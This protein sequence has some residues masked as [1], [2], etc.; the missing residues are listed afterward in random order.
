MVSLAQIV[1]EVEGGES[2]LS[3]EGT[4]SGVIMLAATLLSFLV[5]RVSTRLMR[6]D[7]VPWWP[8]SIVSDGRLHVHH[9]VFGII[10]MLLAG[11]VITGIAV[12]AGVP[13][14]WTYIAEQAPSVERAKHVGTAQL[15]WSIGPLIGA[16]FAAGTA[17]VCADELWGR[18][19]CDAMTIPTAADATEIRTT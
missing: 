11:F 14:S 6:S 17:T 16:E 19:H 3:E 13:A 1:L 15:A 7:K 12:G 4:R 18:P 10:I 2:F 8:G 9:H 5:I